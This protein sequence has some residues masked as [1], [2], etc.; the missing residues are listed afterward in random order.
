MANQTSTAAEPALRFGDL[1]GKV[2]LITGSTT[3]IG[4]AAAAL[5]IQNGTTVYIN[6]RNGD[7]VRKTMDELSQ[8]G[9]GRCMEGTA[10]IAD[11][12][13]VRNL[14]KKIAKEQNS[15]L[16]ILICNA[17]YIARVQYFELDEPEI[18]WFPKMNTK[19]W[20]TIRSCQEAIKLMI[21]RRSGTIVNISGGAAHE[22]VVGCAVHAAGQGAVIPFTMALAQEMR[23]YGIR[24]NVVSPHTVD[25]PIWRRLSGAAPTEIAKVTYP[26]L[27]TEVPQFDRA[28]DVAAAYVFF[29]S[30]VSRAITGQVLQVNGGRHIAN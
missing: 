21:P 23:R 20:G 7:G 16:D 6:G 18:D 3:G 13:Q 4:R 12:E 11:P 29:A 25:T 24:A 19:V 17:E 5:L 8:L 1:M 9:P 14:F 10:D 27:F 28:E 22:G 15:R 2:A 30:D 26:G